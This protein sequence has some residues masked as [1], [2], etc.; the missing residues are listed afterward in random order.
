MRQEAA[1][2]FE[3]LGPLGVLFNTVT[4]WRQFVL[5]GSWDLV[6]TCSWAYNPTWNR[7]MRPLRESISRGYKDGYK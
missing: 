7:C 1:P 2:N 5:L 3:E 4:G 6:T